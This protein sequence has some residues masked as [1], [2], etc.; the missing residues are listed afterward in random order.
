MVK[1]HCFNSSIDNNFTFRDNTYTP[2]SLSDKRCKSFAQRGLSM[3]QAF[4]QLVFT[5][6]YVLQ[7]IPRANSLALMKVSICSIGN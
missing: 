3:L 7:G 6:L 2:K 1:T 5:T 4:R